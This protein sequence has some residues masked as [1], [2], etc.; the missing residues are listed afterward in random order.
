MVVK[1]HRWD[2]WMDGLVMLQFMRAPV[3][4]DSDAPAELPLCGV[5]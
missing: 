1:Y 4:G 3:C 2:G 5:W